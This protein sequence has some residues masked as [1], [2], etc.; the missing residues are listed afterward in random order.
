MNHGSGAGHEHVVTEH[1]HEHER[2]VPPDPRPG[3]PGPDAVEKAGGFRHAIFRPPGGAFGRVPPAENPHPRGSFGY[4]GTF[5]RV[6]EKCG[7]GG[8]AGGT[9]VLPIPMEPGGVAR[10][11]LRVFRWLEEERG[12]ELVR[13]TEPGQTRNYVW[14]TVEGPGIHGLIGVHADP[15]IARTLAI[16][17]SLSDTLEATRGGF[18]LDLARK[19]GDLLLCDPEARRRLEDPRLYRALVEANRRSNLPGFWLPTKK[20]EKLPRPPLPEIDPC[21]ICREVAGELAAE[22]RSSSRTSSPPEAMLLSLST[23]PAALAGAWDL[24]DPAP[25]AA[26]DVLAVHAALLRDGN[27]LYF[28]GSENVGAQNVAGGAAID[29]TRLYDPAANAIAVLPSPPRYDLFCCGHALLADGRLLA[30]GGTKGWGGVAHPNHGTNFEGLRSAAIFEPAAPGGFNPWTPVARL[31]PQRGQTRGGGSWYPTLSLLSDG[32]VAKMGGPPEYEDTRH[33]NRTLEVFDPTTGRWT[34][35]GA[36]SD[37]P[38]SDDFDLPQYPRLHL[39]P[40]GSLFC[41]TPL[42]GTGGPGWQSWA[43]DPATKTWAAAGSGPG[44]GFVG[45]DTSSVLLPLTR[46]SGYRPRVLYVNRDVP[47]WIDLGAPAPAWQATG[48]RALSDPGGGGPPLRYHATAVLLADGTVAVFGGHNDPNNWDPPVLTPEL[49]DPAT[50]TWSVLANAAVPRVY[51]SVALLLPDG[52]VWTHGSDYGS[53]VHE[54]RMEVFSPPYLFRG[55]RPTLTA[56]P[57]VVEIGGN[58]PISTPDAARIATVALVRCGS[59]THAFGIDQRWLELAVTGVGAGRLNLAAPPN[60]HV[61]PPGYYMLFLLD[62]DGVP[63]VAKIL[64][65]QASDQPTI[66]RLYPRSGPAAGAT[67]VTILGTN[68][69]P[70]A[71]VSFGGMPAANVVVASETTITVNSPALPPGTLHDVSVRNPAQPPRALAK[72][73][74]SDFADVPAGHLF[75]DAVERLFRNGVTAGCGPGRFCPDDKVTRAQMALFLMRAEH[76]TGWVPPPPTGTVY[77]DVPAAMFAAGAIEAACADGVFPAGGNFGPGVNVTR[78]EMATLL[79]RA[80]HGAAYVPPPATGIFG[81]VPAADPSA[82]WIERLFHEA[83][84]GGCG[85]GNYCPNDGSTRAE[86]AAFLVRTFGLP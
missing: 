45:F 68:F 11:T 8:P 22:R 66:S 70:G 86:M 74:L 29:K 17:A 9:L 64:R 62:G 26:N 16:L 23:A 44:G 1:G 10:E 52:R 53:G 7:D 42:E 3:D 76:G 75:H 46:A 82:P 36:A 5:A 71:T 58:F 80:E 40:D 20:G 47:Q 34:D 28:G 69:R 2:V 13:A 38:A 39:L 27:I 35:Q 43:W 56:A 24:V 63:S 65:V 72:A 59:A 60:A 33:N 73:W 30:A 83:I 25:A 61:A 31:L 85:G 37:I 21:E 18:A 48:P 49:F 81:D 19:I 50:G 78:A 14:A 57:D 15:L 84:T 55:P 6:P 4:V 32:T 12:W 77:A 79:L 67:A 51:H 41:P 54:M